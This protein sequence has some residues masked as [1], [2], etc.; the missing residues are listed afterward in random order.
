MISRSD[1]GPASK[2]ILGFLS[3]LFP[4]SL[5]LIDSRHVANVSSSNLRGVC[6]VTSETI[7]APQG[8]VNFMATLVE[9]H[10][11]DGYMRS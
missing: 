5:E 6:Q 10:D 7:E 2:S 11:Q 9:S 8:S 4:P 1:V 3:C